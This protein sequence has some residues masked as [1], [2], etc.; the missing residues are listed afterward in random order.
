MKDCVHFAMLLKMKPMPYFTAKRTEIR[1]QF[2]ELLSANPTI[3]HI[4]NPVDKNTAIE[5]GALVRQIEKRKESLT[6]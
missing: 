2:G 5:V 4:L 1:R 6:K 3:K